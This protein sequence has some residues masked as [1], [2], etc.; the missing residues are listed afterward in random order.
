MAGRVGDQRVLA[1]IGRYLR[2]GVLIGESVQA[3]PLGTPQGGPLSPLMANIL[4]DDLD[5]VV[6][7][8]RAEHDDIVEAVDESGLGEA[9]MDRLRR[10]SGVVLDTSDLEKPGRA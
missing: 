3:T 8:E 1:R 9:V 5:K 7:G 4:L 10:A 6:L 2:A